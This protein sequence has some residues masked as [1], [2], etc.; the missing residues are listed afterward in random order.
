MF[1]VVSSVLCGAKWKPAFKANGLLG[2]Q[3]ISPRI[4][5]E[6]GWSSH[7]DIP[8]GIPSEQQLQSIFPKRAKVSRNSLLSWFFKGQAKAKAKA[9]AKAHAKAAAAAPMLA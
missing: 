8:A 4:L 1:S 6:V 5:G 2:E 3:F 9:K 7:P